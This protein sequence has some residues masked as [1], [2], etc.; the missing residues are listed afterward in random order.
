MIQY[1]LTERRGNYM[2]KLIVYFFIALLLSA[3]GD[4]NATNDTT[5]VQSETSEIDTM[6]KN[7]LTKDMGDPSAYSPLSTEKLSDSENYTLFK[8]TYRAKNKYNA[9]VMNES[10]IFFGR[11]DNKIAVI[12][13]NGIF[14]MY[15]D[16]LDYGKN[17]GT[18]VDETY[19][20]L[21]TSASRELMNLKFKDKNALLKTANFIHNLTGRSYRKVEN[22]MN[23]SPVGAAGSLILTMQR[24][25]PKVTVD[26]IIDSY[27]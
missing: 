3:C 20:M 23:E 16:I 8:H 18:Y 10:Y 7:N 1:I 4:N 24:I 27:K 17:G 25:A 2:R 22:S 5:S 12:I 15:K 19:Q 26:A 6:I 21:G 13:P 11:I 14:E 9:L